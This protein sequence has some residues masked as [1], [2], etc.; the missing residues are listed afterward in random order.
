[1]GL[2]PNTWNC[3]LRMRWESWRRFPRH[4]LQRKSLVSDPGMH[5]GTCVTR[6][7][8]CMSGSVSRG[9]G[10]DVPCIPG[11]CTTHN[12]THLVRGPSWPHWGHSEG[13]QSWGA[14]KSTYELLNLRALKFSPMNAIYIFQWI[15]YFVW[16]FKGNLWNSTQNVLPIHWKK[17]FW[18]K[19]DI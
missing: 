6:M 14:F 10:E 19:V 12:F 13:W 17:R 11:T 7:P 15:R 2:L 9:G 18:Y 4:R 8:W 1:M 3:G 5:H 16:N